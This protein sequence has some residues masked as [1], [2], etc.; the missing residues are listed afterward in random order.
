MGSCNLDR[1]LLEVYA[2]TITLRVAIPERPVRPNETRAGLNS[3][4]R[5][6]TVSECASQRAVGPG[7]SAKGLEQSL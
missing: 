6:T 7:E 1:A 5:R 4:P 3:A 2:D